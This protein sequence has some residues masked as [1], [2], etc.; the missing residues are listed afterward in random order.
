MSWPYGQLLCAPCGVDEPMKEEDTEC[1]PMVREQEV[2]LSGRNLFMTNIDPIHPMRVEPKGIS[3]S[4]Q[5]PP[6]GCIEDSAPNTY[7]L[8]NTS[9]QSSHP[10]SEFF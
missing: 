2:K 4:H 3:T 8:G 1:H 10:I 6:P 7:F 5:A 9:I